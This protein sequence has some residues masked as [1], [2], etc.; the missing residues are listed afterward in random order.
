MSD[1]IVYSNLSR[2]TSYFINKPTYNKYSLKI[3][4]NPTKKKKKIKI[5]EKIK[6]TFCNQ[7]N[8]LHIMFWQK[9]EMTKRELQK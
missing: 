1:S 7:F 9:G 4:R 6:R 8:E 3:F 2:T 5:L